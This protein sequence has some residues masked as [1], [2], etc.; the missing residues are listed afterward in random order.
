MTTVAS[1]VLRGFLLR[2]ALWFLRFLFGIAGSIVFLLGGGEGFFQADHVFA[3]LERV[4]RF[5]FFAQFFFGIVGGFDRQSN[6]PLEFVH[7]DNARFDFLAN[8]EHVFDFRDVTLAQ[9]RD[10]DEAVDVVA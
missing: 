5:D 10:V 4:E 3:G 7:F 9:L 8:F 6:A 1:L 2:L